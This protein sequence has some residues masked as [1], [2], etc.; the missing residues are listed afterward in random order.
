MQSMLGKILKTT[1]KRR[2]HK[3]KKMNDFKNVGGLECY[4]W[5]VCELPW[6]VLLERCFQEIRV[7]L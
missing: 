4:K 3:E 5:Q 2:L 7:C 6:T 1:E